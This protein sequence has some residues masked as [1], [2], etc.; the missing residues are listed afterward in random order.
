ME[1]VVVDTV[2]KRPIYINKRKML[3]YSHFR[4]FGLVLCIKEF[5]EG[6]SFYGMYTGK[7]ETNKI[8]VNTLFGLIQSK[9]HYSASFV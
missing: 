9:C 5:W 3:K 6:S 4:C 7:K 1:S 2:P 8:L